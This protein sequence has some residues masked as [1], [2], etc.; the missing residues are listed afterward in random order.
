MCFI[1]FLCLL[2]LRRLIEPA[3]LGENLVRRVIASP[4]EFDK[5]DSVPIGLLRPCLLFLRTCMHNLFIRCRAV[6]RCLLVTSGGFADSVKFDLVRAGIRYAS[7]VRAR[8]FIHFLVV[9]LVCV[10]RV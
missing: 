7:A 8:V 10:T 3:A 6:T 1:I 2:F 9:P 4:G 5:R